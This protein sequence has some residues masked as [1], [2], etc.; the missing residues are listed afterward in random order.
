MGPANARGACARFW[1]YVCRGDRDIGMP[2]FLDES[3]PGSMVD[4]EGVNKIAKIL[5]DPKGWVSYQRRQ[6]DS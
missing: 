1:T 5:F 2:G 4:C 3:D 6:A